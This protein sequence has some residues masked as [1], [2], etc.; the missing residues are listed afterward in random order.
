MTSLFNGYRNSAVD[1]HWPLQNSDQQSSFDMSLRHCFPLSQSLRASTFTALRSSIRHDA[2]R[3]A[4]GIRSHAFSRLA[5]NTNRN[6]PVTKVS[7]RSWSSARG[8]TGAAF[9]KTQNGTWY[10][11]AGV[12]GL[13]LGFAV[14][15][16]PGSALSQPVYCDGTF[17]YS[18]QFLVLE[19]YW[20]VSKRRTARR[21][22]A[23]PV[24]PQ[25]LPPP[26]QSA[27][28]M[29]ELS[30]GT[31]AGLCAGIFVKKGAKIVGFFLGGVFVLLQ[32]RLHSSLSRLVSYR[33][34]TSILRPH[35][36]CE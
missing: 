4:N 22:N 26:P 27:V 24:N 3:N 15:T 5:M 11:Y 20:L 2:L 30:F 36:W 17:L 12:A 13:G 7:S 35:H 21:S 14:S 34:E 31:V 28:N 9:T 6:I 10:A 32:V 18:Y 8:S 19:V 23:P 33:L 25:P 16:M 1:L 29:Y